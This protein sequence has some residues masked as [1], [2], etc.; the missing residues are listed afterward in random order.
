MQ[1]EYA[2]N[3][4]CANDLSHGADRIPLH[5][6]VAVS[7]HGTVEIHQHA[8]K[9]RRLSKRSPQPGEQGIGRVGIRGAAGPGS[10]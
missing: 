8:I 2:G 10:G 1:V 6:A 3:W 9:G 4:D 5:V 7:D